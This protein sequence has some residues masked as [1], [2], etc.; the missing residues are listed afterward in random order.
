[1]NIFNSKQLEQQS[2]Q[3]AQLTQQITTLTARLQAVT[4]E[5]DALSKDRREGTRKAVVFMVRK[6]SVGGSIGRRPEWK[7]KLS[8]GG[9]C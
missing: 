2:A 6:A 3:I 7:L 4:A 9:Q 5:R 8:G 1:M